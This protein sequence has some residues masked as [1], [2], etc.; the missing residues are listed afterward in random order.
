MWPVRPVR[1]FSSQM[2]LPGIKLP[3]DFVVSNSYDISSFITVYILLGSQCPN[4][5]ENE[6]VLAEGGRYLGCFQD[7]VFGRLLE[8]HQVLHPLSGY[9]RYS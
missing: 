8:G 4:F 3:L 7:L 1:E 9:Y 6:T 2:W 5:V